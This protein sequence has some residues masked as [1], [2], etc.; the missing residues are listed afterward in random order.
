MIRPSTSEWAS[1]VVLVKKKDTSW[2]MCIDYRKLN[3]K[4]LNPDSYMLPRIDDTLDALN[5]AKFFCTLDIQQGYHNVELTESAKAKT[6]FHA[7]FCNPSH[8]EYVYMPFGLV[9]AP[10]TFQ[11][12]MDRILQGLDHKIALA[13][14]DDIIVY[15]A[16]MEEV[17]DNLSTVFGRLKDAGVKLKAKKCFLFQKETTY[18]G[19][20]ISSEGVKCDPSKCRQYGTG[21]LQRR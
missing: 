16:T 12:L 4:T 8:W 14:I 1:N 7:P 17:L 11:R 15:G 18:L 19:H 13:Y 2:R 5:R 21:T 6:A 9:R 20:V 10:R 3:A